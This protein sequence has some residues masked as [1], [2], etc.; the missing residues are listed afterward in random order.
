MFNPDGSCSA[1]IDITLKDDD[2]STPVIVRIRAMTGA[3]TVR[4]RGQEDR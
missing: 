4:K 1:D 3:V 2:D